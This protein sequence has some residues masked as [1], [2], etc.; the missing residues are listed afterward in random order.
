MA[1]LKTITVDEGIS[2]WPNGTTLTIDLLTGGFFEINLNNATGT[3][4]TFNT[5]NPHADQISEFTLK[6]TQGSTAR[7]FNWGGLT[8]FK[9]SGSSAPTLTTGN[10]DIDILQ[11]TTYNAGSVWYGK[12]VGQNFG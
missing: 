10:G 1:N 2:T 7:Q 12:V 4:T 8:Q 6:L 11:F 9:W 5:S 3:I